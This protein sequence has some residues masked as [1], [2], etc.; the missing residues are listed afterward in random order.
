MLKV[1]S[2]A[3]GGRGRDLG[4]RSGD[5]I[6]RINGEPVRDQLDYHFAMADE[7]VVIEVLRDLLRMELSAVV[8]AG[9]DLGLEFEAEKIRLCG[10]ECVFCFIDQNPPGMR[11]TL[12][13][14]DEDYRLSFLHGN[15]VTLTNMKTWELE[16]I[17]RQRLSPQYIS[18][19]STDPEIRKR[20]LKPKVE[21][22]ILEAMRYLTSH[23]IVLHA[24][25]VLCP[26][27]NDG[28]DLLHT[29]EDLAR[30]CPE[31]QSLAIVPL[32]LTSHRRGLPKL[33]PVTPEAARQILELVRPYQRR[34]RRR[35]GKTWVYLADEFYRLLG[36]T[37]PA[38]AHYDDFPQLENGIGMTRHFF[39]ALDGA[40][41][42][43]GEARRRGDG[44]FTVVT[45]ELFGPILRR[46]L[47][48]TLE[49]TGELD[50]VR[51][52]LVSVPNSFYGRGVTVAGLLVGRDILNGLQRARR[53]HGTLGER[54]FIPPATVNDDGLF[55]D[56][57]RPEDIASELDVPVS[58]RAFDPTTPLNLY[59]GEGAHEQ[60]TSFQ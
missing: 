50:R 19:H 45:G 10:N 60:A 54:V 22:D 38:E 59:E 12:Y 34:F 37:V 44:T 36:R 11:N 53:Q 57:L 26:G 48:R 23:G 1:A 33:K 21:R 51:L 25:V 9:Q 15:F 16:R 6:C 17:V 28:D 5:Q 24:Q 39:Q 20:L 30:L 2:V 18:V 56:G 42:L 13:V 46:A 7:E 3:S 35:F 47:R 27:Y 40:E 49:R 58:A 14:K 29:I 52:R 43:F 32:G 8:P 41:D 31:V 4:I 55:L